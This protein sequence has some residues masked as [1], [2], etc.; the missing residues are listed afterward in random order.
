M[1]AIGDGSTIYDILGSAAAK[2]EMLAECIDE[3]LPQG[4][5]ALPTAHPDTAAFC[6]GVLTAGGR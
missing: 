1:L 2:I 5:G 3:V 6:S 4:G